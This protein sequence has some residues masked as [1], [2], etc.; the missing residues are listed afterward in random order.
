MSPTDDLINDHKAIKVMLDIMDKIAEN[1]KNG[2]GFELNDIRKII[3]FQKIF[4]EKC[5][6]GKEETALFPALVLEG[7]QNE[8][9]PV[10]VMLNEH[11]SGKRLIQDLSMV[12][13]KCKIDRTC[14]GKFVADTLTKY[15][16]LLK[17]HIQKE[18]TILFPMVNKLLN[19]QKQK[20]IFEQFE[21][22]EETEIGHGVR[23]QHHELLEQLNNK[24][25]G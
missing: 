14:S 18:E 9:G 4:V 20:V 24:Y 6:H 3:D 12:I 10:G 25:S 5:H 8:N 2:N 16:N 11:T 1:I 7:V 17:S 23:E 21:R 19:E 22:I 15:V 13:E